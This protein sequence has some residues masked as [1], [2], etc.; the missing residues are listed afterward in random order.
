MGSDRRIPLLREVF[1]EFPS[2]PINIDI[3]VNDDQLI[4]KV[5]LHAKCIVFK[6]QLTAREVC[7]KMN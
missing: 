3:K 1:K 5:G 6:F 2:V 7:L 4:S